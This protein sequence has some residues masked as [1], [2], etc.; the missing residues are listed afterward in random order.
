MLFVPVTGYVGDAHGEKSNRNDAWNKSTNPS[1]SYVV[2]KISSEAACNYGCIVSDP[3]THEVLHY[4]E[5]PSSYISSTINCGVYLFDT[6]L[7]KFIREVMNKVQSLDSQ[8]MVEGT[9]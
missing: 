9:R 8:I 1:P 6:S 7:F 2:D 3:L 4:V 5:K